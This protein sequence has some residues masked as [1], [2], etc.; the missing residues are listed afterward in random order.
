MYLPLVR[1]FQ[2]SSYIQALRI[3]L[4]LASVPDWTDAVLL[5]SAPFA[6]VL[7]PQAIHGFFWIP[8]SIASI[9]SAD[10]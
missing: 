8:L 10:G 6:D 3:L 4:C 5:E 1:T 2:R 9:G 7:S